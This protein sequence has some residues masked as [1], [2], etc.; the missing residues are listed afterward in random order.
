[1]RQSVSAVLHLGQ[2]RRHFWAKR[3]QAHSAAFCVREVE[4]C[5]A[6]FNS[7]P[8]KENE[9]KALVFRA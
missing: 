3:Y 9:P 6:A 1:M 8:K 7:P 4:F 5:A 2:A